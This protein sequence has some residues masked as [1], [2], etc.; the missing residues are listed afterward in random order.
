MQEHIWERFM[1]Q[2]WKCHTSL[3][4]IFH[5][6]ELSHMVTPNHRD[7]KKCNLATCPEKREADLG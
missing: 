2:A 7:T 3:P 1:D 6:L 5:W 4:F